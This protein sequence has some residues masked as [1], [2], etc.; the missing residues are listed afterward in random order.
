VPSSA[1]FLL[2]RSKLEHG[3]V[4]YCLETFHGEPGPNETVRDSGT[5][6]FALPGGTIRARV[7]I[8]QRFGADGIHAR[9]AL[10][11]TLVGGTGR[12]A[13]AAGTITG[14]GTEVENP[15]GTIDS[16]HLR[17]VIRAPG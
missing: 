14:G 15:P 9:Q 6:T 8:V 2:L 16:Q 10:K 1:C 13:H 7:S 5:M 17:Y 3:S 11:G 4:S 12:Y